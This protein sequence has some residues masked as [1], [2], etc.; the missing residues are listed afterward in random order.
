MSDSQNLIKYVKHNKVRSKP[1]NREE[2]TKV[3][4]EFFKGLKKQ[5]GMRG[6]V[7]MDDIQDLQESIV[8]TFWETKEDMDLFYK[9][10][11]KPF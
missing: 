6:F 11:S 10:D 8:L 7:I 9:S 5:A 2:I 1:G 3:L 4:L